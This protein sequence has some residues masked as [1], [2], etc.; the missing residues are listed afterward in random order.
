[1][2]THR[3]DAAERRA[4]D[5]AATDASVRLG[6]TSRTRAWTVARAGARRETIGGG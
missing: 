6:R 1:M 4:R 3:D 2:M 5:D